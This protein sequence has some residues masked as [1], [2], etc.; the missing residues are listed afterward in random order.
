M[1]ENKKIDKYKVDGLH[2]NVVYEFDGCAFHGC[3][4]CYPN[5]DLQLTDGRSTGDCFQ[6]TIARRKRLEEL[7]YTVEQVWECDVTELLR[8]NQL[9]ATFFANCKISEPISARDSFFGGRTNATKLFHKCT[10]TE[11]IRYLD[12]CSLYPFINKYSYYPI[13]HPEIITQDFQNLSTRPYF[14]II[15]AVILPPRKLFHPLL[16]AR[17]RNKL[18]FTLCQRCA[19]LQLDECNHSDA[20]RA[21]LRKKLELYVKNGINNADVFLFPKICKDGTELLQQVLL[22]S[23][24]VLCMISEFC[25]L[26]IQH[27]PLVISKEWIHVSSTP[28]L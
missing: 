12:F 5:R 4:K 8:C 9:M 23:P 21:L 6:Q 16:P 13:G 20:D 19:E 25:C 15:K 27:Y 10:G 26:T 22:R 17:I 11:R 2:E 24:I 28:F 18:I 3:P 7:G 1:V 14:G